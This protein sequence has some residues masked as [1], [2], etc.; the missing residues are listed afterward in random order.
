MIRLVILDSR[1]SF[2]GAAAIRENV[3]LAQYRH[4][5]KIDK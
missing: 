3:N 2:A 4:G 5:I 1:A